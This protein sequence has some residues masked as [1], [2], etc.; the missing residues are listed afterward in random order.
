MCQFLIFTFIVLPR[1]LLLV[2]ANLTTSTGEI[3]CWNPA[4][5]FKFPGEG[6]MSD[7]A[8]FVRRDKPA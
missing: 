1:Y 2:A 5:T 7:M 4:V 6:K 3:H 8:I